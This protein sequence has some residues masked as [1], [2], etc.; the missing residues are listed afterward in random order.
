V[1]LYFFYRSGVIGTEI[2]DQSKR[3]KVVHRVGVLQDRDLCSCGLAF[4]RCAWEMDLARSWLL[5]ARD[6][7][8]S[9]LGHCRAAATGSLEGSAF[10][11]GYDSASHGDPRLF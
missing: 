3:K 8:S 2:G 6:S 9:K 7:E 1:G 4:G 10:C 11:L 5:D